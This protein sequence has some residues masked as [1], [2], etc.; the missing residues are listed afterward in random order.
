MAQQITTLRERIRAYEDLADY[1]LLPKVPVIITLNGRGFRKSSSL[2]PKP[3]SEAFTELMV[4][5]SIKLSQEVEGMALI[6]SF[7]DEIVIVARNDHS[8]DASCWHDNRVQRLASA[9]AA[10]ATLGFNKVARDSGI[11]L[12]GDAV[13]LSGAF[14]VP[15]VME[16]TNV[17]LSKQQQC[18]HSALYN[19]CFYEL[20]KR[21]PI[22]TVRQTLSEK[23]AQG[24]ADILLEQ[25]GIDFDS[26][27]LCERR[28]FALYHRE[29]SVL[30]QRGEEM[31]TKLV[32]DTELPLFVKTPNYLGS[33]LKR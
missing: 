22:D 4:A 23:T 12:L 10:I 1:R 14:T 30:T 17:L 25:C 24:K 32:V 16:A 15:S 8:P 27:G 20:L 28:G 13:F 18:F 9:T 6:Y 2:L 33:I 3:F 31:K 26:Y 29:E 11:P 5:T 7:N 19:A 21:H